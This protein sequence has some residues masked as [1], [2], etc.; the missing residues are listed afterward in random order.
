MSLG[1]SKLKF[2]P[3][4]LV[5]ED[6]QLLI[7]THAGDAVASFANGSSHSWSL[8]ELRKSFEMSGVGAIRKCLGLQVA[9]EKDC[10]CILHQQQCIEKSLNDFKVVLAHEVL[11]FC[12]VVFSWSFN[13]NCITGTGP[14]ACLTN[15][16]HGTGISTRLTPDDPT[17]QKQRLEHGIQ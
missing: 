7:G 1:F 5:H 6:K 3:C 11:L 8:A 9:R 2:D 16:P 14:S 17:M 12:H 15:C 13:P 10:S 4:M